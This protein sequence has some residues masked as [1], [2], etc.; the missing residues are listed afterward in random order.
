MAALSDSSEGAFAIELAHGSG[1]VRRVHTIDN[2]LRVSVQAG[3]TLLIEGTP[4]SIQILTGAMRGVAED[5]EEIGTA[6]VGRHAHIEYLGDDDLWRA[7]DT[8]PLVIGSDC[9]DESA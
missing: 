3:P 6:P 7:P 5:A 4:E 2:R 8:F 1:T 9:P